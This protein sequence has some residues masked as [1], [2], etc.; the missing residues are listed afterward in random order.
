MQWLR[1]GWFAYSGRGGWLTC[2]PAQPAA[3][4]GPP[5]PPAHTTDRPM[6]HPSQ[7]IPGGGTPPCKLRHTHSHTP[8]QCTLPGREGGRGL[9]KRSLARSLAQLTC[10]RAASSFLAC[11]AARRA[12]ISCCICSLSSFSP[13]FRSSRPS[14]AELTQAACRRGKVGQLSRCSYGD[15]QCSY[16]QMPSGEGREASRF[17]WC[18]YGDAVY[19]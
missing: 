4:E 18:S 11:M 13:I 7:A 8:R 16:G 19:K 2:S 12:A 3:H 14:I 1:G 15:S 9:R 10:C 5:S 6:R 17:V